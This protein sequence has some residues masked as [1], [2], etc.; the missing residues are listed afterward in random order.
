MGLGLTSSITAHNV[1]ALS[2]AGYA[3][4]G[5]RPTSQILRAEREALQVYT[6]APRHAVPPAIF[7]RFKEVGFEVQAGDLRV[8]S[9]AARLRVANNSDLFPRLVAQLQDTLDGDGYCIAYRWPPYLKDSLF[10]QVFQDFQDSKCIRRLPEDIQRKNVQNKLVQ[11][12][13]PDFHS[14]SISSIIAPR[15][16]KWLPYISEADVDTS[17]RVNLQ[18]SMMVPPFVFVALLRTVFNNWNTTQ[19]CRQGAQGCKFGCAC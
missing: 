1:Y 17:F 14:R 9:L 16:R 19:R 5:S 8:R 3:S 7:A 15:L 6:C 11:M 4:Q 13:T 2:V 18:S 10:W 12:I